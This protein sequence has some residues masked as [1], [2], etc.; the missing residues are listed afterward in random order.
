MIKIVNNSMPRR[1]RCI[2]CSTE[3]EYEYSDIQKNK[4]DDFVLHMT[5]ITSYIYCPICKEKITLGQF[6]KEW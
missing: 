4:E 3:L 5:I 2:K 1:I 6:G